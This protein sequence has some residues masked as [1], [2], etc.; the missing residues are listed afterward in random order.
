M[1]MIETVLRFF[2]MQIKYLLV[3]SSKLKQPVF[4]IAP[5]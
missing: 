4:S 1:H 2:K 3:N 5:K